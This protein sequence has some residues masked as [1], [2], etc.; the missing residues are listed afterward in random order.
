MSS[1]TAVC[2]ALFY[3]WCLHKCFWKSVCKLNIFGDYFFFRY[4]DDIDDEMDP[5]IE[6]AFEKFCLESEDK[7]KQWDV[8][9]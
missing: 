6:E 1:V 3:A 8:T 5:E 4:F 9:Y 2:K 7:R